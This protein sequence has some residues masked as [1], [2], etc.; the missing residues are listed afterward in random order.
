MQFDLKTVNGILGVDESYKAPEKMLSLMLDDKKR[1]ETFKK[2]LEVSTDMSFDWFHEYYQDEQ[3]ERKS[4]KQDFTPDGIA[5][6]LNKLVEEDRSTGEYFEPAAGTG[7]VLIKRW[8]NDR[9]EDP[10]HLAHVKQSVLDKNR[11]ISLFTYDPRNYW[12]QAEE[13]SDRA[14]P[15]LIFNMS[16]RGM[17]GV[18]V[19]CDS[20][21]RKAKEVYFIRNNTSD[22]LAFS[23]VIKM[24]HIKGVEQFYHI[25][26]WVKEF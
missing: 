24:P 9:I 26:E 22:Y 14:V 12:Y 7:G 13:M 21:N 19:Q 2:F 15:F 3:A 1:P 11:G 6:L 10:V 20:L 17:N 25:K 8:W 23:D 4:Q 16:I 18:V 5:Q